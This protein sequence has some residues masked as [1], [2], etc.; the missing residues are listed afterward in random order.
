[1][2]NSYQGLLFGQDPDVVRRLL[3]I[4][5]IV[6]LRYFLAA[7]IAWLLCY[8]VFRNR[9]FHRKVLPQFPKA[10]DIRREFG[11]SILT[12]FIAS[13]I[14]VATISAAHHGWTRMYFRV[15]DHGRGWFVGSICLAILIHD[16]YFYWTHRLMHLPRLFPLFHRVH[17]LSNNPSPWAAYSFG[18]AEAVVQSGIFPLTVMILPM[19]PVAFGLFMLWQILVNVLGHSGFEFH[20]KFL[21]HTPLRFI[22]NTP[23]HHVMHHEKM[24]G[25]YGLNFN[26]WDR[27]M[28]TNHPDYESRLYEV[29]SRSRSG[30]M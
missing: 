9:W 5:T 8:V 25:N 30:V 14:G 21:M 24:R 23:T 10:S 4:M 27:L 6:G 18:P 20:P 15:S 12:A 19:H 1:M 26:L 7:G 22:L 2:T 13:L 11:Y 3:N 16:T 17:H 28:G 29:T